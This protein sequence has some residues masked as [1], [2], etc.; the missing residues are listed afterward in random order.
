[1]REIEIPVEQQ[2]PQGVFVCDHAGLVINKFSLWAHVDS[3]GMG[4]CAGRIITL[5]GPQVS[6]LELSQGWGIP[7]EA[8]QFSQGWIILELPPELMVRLMVK[9]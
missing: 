2:L 8:I 1:M 9:S 3:A 5:N 6:R 4:V 7:L